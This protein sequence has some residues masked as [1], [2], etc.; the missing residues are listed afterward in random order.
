MNARLTLKNSSVQELEIKFLD[1][2]LQKN[3]NLFTVNN[4]DLSSN[5]M[6]IS[7]LSKNSQAYFSVDNRNDIYKLR[8]SY[9][10]KDSSRIP[11][12]REVSNFSYF[13]LKKF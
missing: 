1:I 3:K 12:L 13:N 5:L 6:S 2:Y 9:L 8:G 11:I 4:I 7:A 10:I